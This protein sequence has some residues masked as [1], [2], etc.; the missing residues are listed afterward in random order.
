[1]TIVFLKASAQ[2]QKARHYI[3]GRE[4]ANTE[5]PVTPEKEVKKVVE[6]HFT[7]AKRK[8]AVGDQKKNRQLDLF[9][10]LNGIKNIETDKFKQMTVSELR[11]FT[12]DY[13]NQN[14]KGKS[15]E[16]KNSL[17]KVSFTTRQQ[18]EK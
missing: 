18:V 11:K 1:M 15:T 5:T 3:L 13:Y 12:L 4:V 14:L 2:A 10:G 16:I 9:E 17:K 7:R 8:T 6:N